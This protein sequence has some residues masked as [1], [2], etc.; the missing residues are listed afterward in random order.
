MKYYIITY[1]CQM[2][3]S[4]SERL[5]RILKQKGGH[6]AKSADSANLVLINVCSVRQSAVN[7]VYAKV[8]KYYK[9]K[10]IILAGCILEA[11][12]K[13][14]KDKVFEFWHP[15]KYFECV[16]VHESPFTAYVPIMTGCNNFCSYCVVPYTRGLEKSR[17][18]KKIIKE[19]KSLI[20]KGHKEIVLLGQNVNSY[21]FIDKNSSAEALAKADS[22]IAFPQLLKKVS[23]IPG[24]FWL[25]FLT[26]HP[27]DMSGELIE[28]AAKCEKV[29]PYIHLPVQSGDD[30]IL[31]KMN[32]YYTAVHY[33]NLIKKIR[34]I[35][36]EY[37]KSF[38]PVA[39]STDII[40][41]FPGETKK[42]F[43]NSAKMMKKIKFDM[44][45]IAK[46]SPRLGTAAAKLKDNVSPKEKAKRWNA[47][48]KILNVISLENNKKYI[49]KNVEV[50]IYE[51]NK[52]RF[53]GR[54]A[55]GKN[56][57]IT[58]RNAK[59]GDWAKVKVT[60]ANSWGMEGE[61]LKQKSRYFAIA[62]SE[63]RLDD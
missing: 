4:D 62:A 39:I 3:K 7:R 29:I 28:T 18:T 12:K 38:P 40:V 33:K 13:K 22:I 9:T 34:T 1:G 11:D 6:R 41:G 16:P 14:L 51:K 59:I 53:L 49:G 35:F 55:T 54:T 58:I 42:Q 47:L 17:P 15:D 2:N 31:R 48:N 44:V 30:E 5:E 52:G 23:A 20:K 60:D 36:K 45:Y 10:K 61:I 21:Q 27:K 24:H 46:Y 26:S 57:A 56:V 50:L 63:H 37:R 25:S 19:V 8:N 43:A 32:R